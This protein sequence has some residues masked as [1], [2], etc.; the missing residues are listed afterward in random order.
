MSID[1]WMVL[2][3]YL[4]NTD[5]FPEY[6]GGYPLSTW[7]GP[8]SSSAEV[9]LAWRG[10]RKSF[11]VVKLGSLQ[12]LRGA[13]LS[14]SRVWGVVVCLLAAMMQATNKKDGNPIEM[15]QLK[16]KQLDKNVKLWLKKQP[17]AVEVALV[18]AG[19][20]VQGG[21]IGAL[22]GTFSADVASSMPT[23]PPGLNP[24]AAASLQQA[25]VSLRAYVDRVWTLNSDNELR[26]ISNPACSKQMWI[27]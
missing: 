20:A 7:V 21:A 27:L 16:V 10:R 17:A 19:S 25:K 13:S 12:C 9:E 23:A 15:I 24:E 11:A 18:T 5:H 6:P 4:G 1:T 2:S 14:C 22:M 26:T 8:S 3:W